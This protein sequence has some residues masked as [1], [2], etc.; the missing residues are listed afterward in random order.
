MIREVE[1][2]DAI[3]ITIACMYLISGGCKDVFVLLLAYSNYYKS[4]L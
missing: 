4:D 1:F 3:F 2:Y